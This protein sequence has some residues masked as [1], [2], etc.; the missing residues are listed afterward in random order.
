M[1]LP[2]LRSRTVPPQNIFLASQLVAAQPCAKPDAS[3]DANKPF[4][5]GY[6]AVAL[7]VYSP[8]A[9]SDIA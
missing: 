5:Y 2:L 7:V 6:A 3:T 4:G 9:K 8:A 1:G